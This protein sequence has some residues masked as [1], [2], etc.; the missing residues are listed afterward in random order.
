MSVGIALYV[1]FNG[2]FNTDKI[3]KVVNRYFKILQSDPKHISWLDYFGTEGKNISKKKYYE[4]RIAQFACEDY[5]WCRITK[6]ALI[7]DRCKVLMRL[8]TY[9]ELFSKFVLELKKN[10]KI[11]YA[12][13]FLEEQNSKPREF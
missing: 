3:K 4:N 12:A 8:E 7:V 10:F 11:K 6:K 2:R 1:E 5:W 9:D 13:R